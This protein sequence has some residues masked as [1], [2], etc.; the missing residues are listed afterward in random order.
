M[1]MFW[2]ERNACIYIYLIFFLLMNKKR[3]LGFKRSEAVCI[4]CIISLHGS[5]VNIRTT[6]LRF[7]VV[8]TFSCVCVGGESACGAHAVGAA[9]DGHTAAAANRG[10]A[11][12]ARRKGTCQTIISFKCSTP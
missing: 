3:V 6:L 5:V 12:D 1:M 7:S 11:A 2:L 10:S 8:M 9:G 4:L